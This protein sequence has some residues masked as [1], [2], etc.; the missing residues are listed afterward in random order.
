[1]SETI[2]RALHAAVD[3]EGPRE[4]R[5]RDAAELIRSARNYCWTGIYDAGDGEIA[6]V[7]A[8][9]VAARQSAIDRR[10]TVA[11]RIGAVVP[12]LGAESAIV[13]GTLEIETDGIITF[14]SDDVEFLEA[15]A[16]ALRPLYD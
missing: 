12:V 16:D 9:G 6:L 13:I 3:N 8:S 7:G 1:M 4:E 15:C 5:A 11:P 10:V 2:A 14:G